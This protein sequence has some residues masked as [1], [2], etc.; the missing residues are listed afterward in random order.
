MLR[1]PYGVFHNVKEAREIMT[2]SMEEVISISQVAGINLNPTD[3]LNL[4][5]ANLNVVSP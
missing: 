4:I 5:L 2:A 1:A 3:I